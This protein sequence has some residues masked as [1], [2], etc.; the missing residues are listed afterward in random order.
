MVIGLGVGTSEGEGVTFK[1]SLIS[2]KMGPNLNKVFT[3]LNLNADKITMKAKTTT[4]E[5]PRA[6]QFAAAVL[7]AVPFLDLAMAHQSGVQIFGYFSWALV[8]FA[9]LSLLVRHKLS[10][11]AGIL[12]CVTFVGVTAVEMLN[13]LETADA[14]VNTARFLDCLLVLFIVATV[15]YFFRYPYLDRRQ[16][17]FAPTGER[18]AVETAVILGSASGLTQDLSYT[19]AKLHL[20]EEL[21][22]KEGDKLTLRF[23]A[24][25]GLTCKAKI[26]SLNGKQVRVHFEGLSSSEK[27][28]LRNW[29]EKQDAK[30]V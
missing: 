24:M 22:A 6:V 13:E 3:S 12:L 25:S 27:E 5:R 16:N 10:W 21:N 14:I 15:S 18:Y 4:L 28:S 19:G 29:L 30:K 17:W 8:V 1:N 23:E 26:L 9:G 7:I 11:M 2:K 20:D